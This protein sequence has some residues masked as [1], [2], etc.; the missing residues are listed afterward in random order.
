VTPFLPRCCSSV[1]AIVSGDPMPQ[2]NYCR[3]WSCGYSALIRRRQFL[4]EIFSPSRCGR[5]RSTPRQQL[6]CRRVRCRQYNYGRPYSHAP[7]KIFD[8]IVSQTNTAR[9]HEGANR[10]WLIGAVDPILRVAE[11]HRACAERIGFT[12]GHEARQVRLAPNH[13]LRRT[14][15]RPFF[16]E[17]DALG[18]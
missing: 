8:I 12:T 2:S 5:R 10:R 17:A 15:I 4:T 7:V 3:P 11:I 14:P 6:R 1:T 9:G 13:L 16:H 18:A